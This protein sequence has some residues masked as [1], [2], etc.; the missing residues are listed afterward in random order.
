MKRQGTPTS[1]N[2]ENSSRNVREHY[3]Q[4]KQICIFED[5]RTHEVATMWPRFHAHVVEGNHYKIS[6][7]CYLS[8]KAAGKSVKDARTFN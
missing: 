1:P 8:I 5:V 6:S 4:G 2:E 3:V 7:T